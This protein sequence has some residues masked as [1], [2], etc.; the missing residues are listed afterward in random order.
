MSKALGACDQIEW[1]ILE[2]ILIIDEI[3]K[4]EARVVAEGLL[5]LISMQ[6]LKRVM[7]KSHDST[8]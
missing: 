5:E 8:R 6:G 3:V 7:S 1:K 2:Q 4:I